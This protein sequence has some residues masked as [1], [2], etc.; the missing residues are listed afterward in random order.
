M[1]AYRHAFH[2]GNHADVLKHILL[3]A[4]LRHLNSKEKPYWV[5]DTH[6]GAGG[7]GLDSRYARHHGENASGIGRLWHQT[8]LAPLAADYVDLVRAFN[9]QHSRREAD[10]RDPEPGEPLRQYPGSPELIRALLRDQDRARFFELHPTDFEILQA[11]FADD[12]RIRVASTDGYLAVKALLP[13]PPRRALVFIDPPYEIKT[14]YGRVFEAVQEGLRRFAQGMFMVWMPILSRREPN[15]LLERL[16]RQL[17]VDWLAVRLV[18]AEPD[19]GGFGILGSSVFVANPP[20]TL[21]DQ[22]KRDL[23]LLQ[24]LLA[25]HAG[26]SFQLEQRVS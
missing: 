23:P 22:L 6:A 18:V 19:P 25:Q 14:D 16:T 3:V 24:Q 4:A 10:G 2:A 21:H 11:H 12:Q 13:P 26:A 1:L 5:I 15:R 20:W 8:D 7:Y 9:R 17:E